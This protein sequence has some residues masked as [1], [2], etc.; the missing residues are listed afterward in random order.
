MTKKGLQMNAT[1]TGIHNP[2]F[3]VLIKTHINKPLPPPPTKH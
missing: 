3:D 2:I 1:F